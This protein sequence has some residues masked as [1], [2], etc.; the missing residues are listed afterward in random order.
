MTSTKRNRESGQ[1]LVMTS[2]SLLAMFGL[3]GLAVDVGWAHFQVEAAQTAADAAAS[4]AAEAALASSGGSFTCGT[5]N[6][7]CQATTACPNPIPA[8]PIKTTDIACAYAN[9]NGFAITAGGRQNVTVAAGTGAV[10]TASGITPSYWVT[11]RVAETIPQLFSAVLGNKTGVISARATAAISGTAPGACIYILSPNAS[12]AFSIT[13]TSILSA[14]GCG[15]YDNSSNAAAFYASGSP[16]VTSSVILVNGGT[17]ISGS[18]TVNPTPT[19]GAGGVADPLASLPAPAVGACN[20]L[21]SGGGGYSLSSSQTATLNPGV[22]CGGI[23]VAGNSRAT[24]NPGTYILNGGGLS[25]V[26]SAQLSGAGVTFFNTAKTGYT[27]GPVTSTGNAVVNLSA[28][29]SGAYE[30]ILFYQDR[31]ITYAA[32]NSFANSASGTTSGTFYFPTTAVTYTGNVGAAIYDA[33][34]CST[35]SIT[36]SSSFKN[37]TS[38]TYTGL[39]K[40]QA[41]LIE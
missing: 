20:S 3:L 23:S 4:A 19:T 5:K 38:G 32:A 29:T 41:N 28:P 9:S 13:G 30:G 33:F 27:A 26:N 15:I 39:A 36:G 40:P 22:Y 14:S 35:M 25:V 11:V 8:S 6:V 17:S 16:T 21:T 10:P 31:T 2:L 34:V 37:D 1:V 18:S 7:V 24:L 12:H